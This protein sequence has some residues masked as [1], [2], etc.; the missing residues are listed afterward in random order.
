MEDVLQ[1]CVNDGLADRHAEQPMDASVPHLAVPQLPLQADAVSSRSN[2]SS[3]R[4]SSR[5][6]KSGNLNDGNQEIAARVKDL[7]Q[8][9]D[10]SRDGQLDKDELQ[11][12]LKI[13]GPS[14]MKEEIARWCIELDPSGD[15]QVSHR[16]FMDW[17][18][19]GNEGARM[20]YNAIKSTAA[21][22]E[23]RI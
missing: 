20:V 8:R 3:A 21:K 2:A 12:V 22:R 5:R 7:F 13:L 17:I 10:K 16:E 6:E 4:A 9:Y 18:R 23:I 11:K 19:Q 14:F 1:Y 15:G